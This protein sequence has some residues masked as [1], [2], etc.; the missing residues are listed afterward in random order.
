MLITSENKKDAINMVKKSQIVGRYIYT[1]THIYIYIY[2]KTILSEC[3]KSS[4][5][6]D[7]SLTPLIR[8][9]T[10]L[11]TQNDIQMTSIKEG[12]QFSFSS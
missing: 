4:S 1:H 3:M 7:V 10:S 2:D 6:G 8:L 9:F 11:F 12:A 5:R